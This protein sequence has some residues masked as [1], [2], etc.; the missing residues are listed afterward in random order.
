MRWVLFSD[1]IIMNFGAAVFFVLFC[2]LLFLFVM[3]IASL[4]VRERKAKPFLPNISVVIPAY[5]EEDAIIQCLDATNASSYP[6]EKREIIVVDD[7]STDRTVALVEGYRRTH[8]GITLIRAKHQGKVGALNL[9]VR[10]ARHDFILSLDADATVGKHTIRDLVAPLRD[11]AVGAAN[12]IAAIRSPTSLLE[13][14]QSI[15]FFLNNIIRTSFSKLFKNSIW[16]FGVAACYRRSAL[17]KIGGFK[18]D[19]LTEDMDCSLELFNADYRIVTVKD[20][21]IRTK[22]CSTVKSLF[23][24]RMRW[25][26]GALQALAKNR[27]RAKPSVPV[28]FIYFNQW[29]WTFFSFAFFPL[30]AYQVRYWLPQ[31]VKDIALYLFRWFTLVGPFYVLYKIPV[32]GISALNI[33]GV[34]SGIITLVLSLSAF[35]MFHE[36]VRPMTLVALFFYF[37]YTMLLNAILLVGVFRYRFSRKKYFIS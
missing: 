25:Y 29:W 5:N 37:P 33:F 27:K 34:L 24:Q 8:T 9:G 28:A 1:N 11:P 22:P 17:R 10:K 30:V 20:A 14:F 26:Y 2:F 13:H 6:T 7:A 4:F 12:C 35:A 19:T 21:M 15:E 3:F 16:F 31:G 23:S 36:K 32:W 18:K